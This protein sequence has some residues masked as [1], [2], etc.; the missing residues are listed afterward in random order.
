MYIMFLNQ[1]FID[2]YEKKK[3]CMSMHVYKLLKPNKFKYNYVWYQMHARI[4][5]LNWL[6]CDIN[7]CD[8]KL[9]KVSQQLYVYMD[10]LI[11]YIKLS[12]FIS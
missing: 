5:C 11:S 7:F 9:F 4:I 1:L 2:M 3:S 6:T 10:R 8:K 12:M